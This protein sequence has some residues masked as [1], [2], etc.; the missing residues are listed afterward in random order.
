MPKDRSEETSMGSPKHIDWEKIVDAVEKRNR[1]MLEFYGR[2]YNRPRLQQ[3]GVTNE[4]LISQI[5]S[6]APG[7]H[8]M[9]GPLL[10][11]LADR[12]GG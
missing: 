1:H 5:M 10:L 7:E 8:P 9:T 11:D 6:L 12:I 3:E 2:K 4:E